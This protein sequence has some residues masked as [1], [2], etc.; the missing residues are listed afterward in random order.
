MTPHQY[1]LR[2]KIEGASGLLMSSDKNVGEISDYFGFE[3]Q[4]HFSR[5][6]K[7]CTGLSPLAY[8]KTYLQKVDW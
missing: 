2:L 1:F 7:K 3:N 5:M 8:R 6:F 4:F